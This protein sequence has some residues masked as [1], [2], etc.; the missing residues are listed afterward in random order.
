MC[1]FWLYIFF[2]KYN[3][4]YYTS[5]RQYT[6]TQ[7]YKEWISSRQHII[8]GVF[9]FW[10]RSGFLILRFFV[11]FF[12]LGREEKRSSCPCESNHQTVPNVTN[13]APDSLR[14]RLR[15]ATSRKA[16]HSRGRLSLFVSDL[17]LFLGCQRVLVN[18]YTCTSG[19]PFVLAS[20]FWQLDTRL[21]PPFPSSSVVCDIGTQFPLPAVVAVVLFT[22]SLSR[23]RTRVFQL[24]LIHHRLDQGPRVWDCLVSL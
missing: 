20:D 16:F 19:N 17:R 23:S 12:F 8:F 14:Q 7:L 13:S 10:A 9:G 3:Y 24:L 18:C 6:T 22:I 2:Q 1:T 11:Y 5:Y 15:S 4:K 21:Y